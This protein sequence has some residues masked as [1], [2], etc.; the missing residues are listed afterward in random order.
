M[1]DA[2][3]RPVDGLSGTPLLRCVLSLP[4]PVARYVGTI[5]AS[6]S[7]P[8]ASSW[9]LSTVWQRRLPG[10]LARVRF[11]SQ[12]RLIIAEQQRNEAMGRRQTSIENTIVAARAGIAA[13]RGLVAARP[14]RRL[15]SVLFKHQHVKP[16][17]QDAVAPLKI[18]LCLFAGE[19]SRAQCNRGL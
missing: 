10:V 11:A 14:F 1:Q 17:Y 8:A 3:V 7:F 12:S 19:R 5:R 16:I 6:F 2:I 4:P 18:G 9:L 15:S 13:R